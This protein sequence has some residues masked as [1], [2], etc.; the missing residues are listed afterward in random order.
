MITDSI[1]MLAGPTAVGKTSRSL[2]IAERLNAEIIS[3]DSR[4]VY[5]PLTIGTAKPEP[6]E[7]AR[8]PHH[9]I[10]ELDLGAPFSAGL[11]AREAYARIRQIRARGRVPMVVGGSPLYLHALQHGLASVPPVAPTIRESLEARLEAEGAD[12][13]FHELT[14]FDPA[15]AKTLDPTKTQRLIRGLEVYYGTGR[16]LSAFH[17]E[18]QAPPF[19]F[20][21]VVL[22]RERKV[23]Y[24]R[25]ERRVD[26]ML[27]I[28][29]LDEVRTLLDDGTD[30]HDNALQ[31]I[32]Y[33]EPIA[34]FRG[35]ID[36]REMVRLIKR[37]TRRYAKRQVTWFRRFSSVAIT[38]YA[39]FLPCDGARTNSACL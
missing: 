7:L 15:F 27:E 28:G 38:D 1:L 10:N 9:F 23:L 26:Q 22:N 25:I 8:V 11:F 39:G 4:Q 24:E 5:R 17:A 16:P 13:L 29:L 12:V 2:A 36:Y 30:P 18:Q 35:D 19:S 32:G 21:V 14:Q 3:A 31:T 33:Q 34:Y 20:T 6:H 37:N